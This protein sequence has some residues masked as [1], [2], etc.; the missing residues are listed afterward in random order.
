[1]PGTNTTMEAVIQLLYLDDGVYVPPVVYITLLQLR[2]SENAGN[3]GMKVSRK[4]RKA[5]YAGA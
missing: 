3:C 2:P 4:G 5:P 1:M